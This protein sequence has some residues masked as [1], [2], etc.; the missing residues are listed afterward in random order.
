MWGK[1][2]EMASLKDPSSFHDRDNSPKK[3]PVA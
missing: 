3:V 2:L 1:S